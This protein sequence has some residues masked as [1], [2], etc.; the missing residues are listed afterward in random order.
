MRR[1]SP[2]VRD[3]LRAIAEVTDRSAAAPTGTRSGPRLRHEPALDGIRGLAV[4]AVLLFH[5]EVTW[6]R[7]GFLGVST[8]F[9]LSGFL[10]TA[11]LLAEWD[12]TGRIDL[13][14]FWA[15]RARRLLP[16]ALLT[17]AGIALYGALVADATQL[18]ALRGDSL[19]ALGYVANWHF[20]LA[21]HSYADLFATPSPVQHFWSLAI[22]E[23]FY[24]VFPLIAAALLVRGGRHRN[25]LRAMRSMGVVLLVLLAASVALA[26][27]LWHP[28]AD[29]ARVYYGTDTRAAEL[30]AGALLA[31]A[32]RSGT[33]PERA[34]RPLGLLALPA[35]AGLVALWAT[36]TPA[37]PWLYRGGLVG[38]A[39][40]AIVVIAGAL[41]GG[42]AR[43]LLSLPALTA[44]GVISYGVYLFH[45]PVFL[46]LD[47][48]RTGL[49]GAPLLAVR[50]A[51]TIG[52][53]VL[54][55]RYLEQ[56]IRSGRRLV[57]WR[58][59]I[60]APVALATVVA[61]TVLATADVPPPS[62]VF[63]AA[64]VSAAPPAPAPPA[65]AAR[66][67]VRATPAVHRIPSAELAPVVQTAAAVVAPQGLKA[68]RAPHEGGLRVM[69]VGDSVAMTVGRGLERW[70]P[71]NGAVVWNVARLYCGIGRGGD[72]GYRG[73]ASCETWPDLWGSDVARFDP[74]A[75]VVLSA[76][77]DMAPRRRD[78]WGDGQFHHIGEPQFDQWMLG[79]Y[80]AAIDV[81]AAR[82]AHVVMLTAP[83]NG[84][85]PGNDADAKLLNDDVIRPAA[86]A[87]PAVT[88]VLDLAAEV[89]PGGQFL[90]SYGGAADARPDGLHFSDDGADA[91]ATW[92]GPRTVE[93]ALVATGQ[94]PAPPA[95][96]PALPVWGG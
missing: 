17:L 34:R 51:T 5:G 3:N 9:T 82:G 52:L 66:A 53:A 81:L 44:L 13:G 61:V 41:A 95:A 28:G 43:R 16:A 80:E 87:R 65:A 79:E 18:A 19:S 33:V 72:M 60:V 45:W 54:S 75:V 63:A 10:I 56:P 55:Y 14:R 57:G 93:A 11:L 26:F 31:I 21:G 77:W 94:R 23:Q 30:L 47:P 32:L 70:G 37:S 59:R 68:T 78:E 71:A 74:D 22:E 25:R 6:M 46:W 58:P 86:A 38:A 96:I 27:L 67:T 85:E 29:T 48:A 92:L 50:V 84:A 73:N 39:A 69:V 24:L 89:C 4:A 42:P 91:L 20:V 36:A 35:L 12:E 40:L 1:S 49:D 8:F 88:H 90:G 64:T 83:C 15:R 62:I 7:G 2:P 76:L